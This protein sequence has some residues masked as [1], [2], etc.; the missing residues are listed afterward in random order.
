MKLDCRTRNLFRLMVTLGLC[1]TTSGCPVPDDGGRSSREGDRGES[2]GTFEQD[3]D[4]LNTRD[5]AA[6]V[7]L[8]L[9]FDRVSNNDDDRGD[10]DFSDTSSG[11][12]SVLVEADSL[13]DEENDCCRDGYACAGVGDIALCRLICR[14]EEDCDS[15]QHCLESGNENDD[16]VCLDQCDAVHQTGC[17]DDERCVVVSFDESGAMLS[18]CTPLS[19]PPL[20]RDGEACEMGELYFGSC[21]P[22]SYCLEGVDG[23]TTCN[24]LCSSSEPDVCGAPRLCNNRLIREDMG[25]C[26]GDCDPFRQDQ[27]DELCNL[28]GIGIDHNGDDAGIGA[29]VQGEQSQNHGDYCTIEEGGGHDCRSGH[30]CIFLNQGAASPS[31]A[32]LCRVGDAEWQCPADSECAVRLLGALNA[33][34]EGASEVIGVCL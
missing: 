17:G 13:C 30:L 25:L 1:L 8:A 3:T 6:E 20:H 10:P 4:H 18:V 12:C 29:C 22:D 31:C 15:A 14:S 16:S 9:D 32:Q 5:S 7:D 33:A 28:V 24:R 34:G 26:R 23:V 21:S 2:E 11:R 27:C 19:E